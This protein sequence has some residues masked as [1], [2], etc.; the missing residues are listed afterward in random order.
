MAARVL[1]RNGKATPCKAGGVIHPFLTVE[2]GEP[3][4][5]CRCKALAVDPDEPIGKG[6][7]TFGEAMRG[8]GEFVALADRP[9]ATD[10]VRWP[11]PRV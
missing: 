4:G 3:R 10:Y 2:S 6:P 7:R 5:P 1:I 9:P 8:L 11:R